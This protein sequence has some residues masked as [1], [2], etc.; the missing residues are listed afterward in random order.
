MH[1]SVKQRFMNIGAATAVGAVMAVLSTSAYAQV[2]SGPAQ[3]GTTL[4]ASKTIEIC[5]RADGQWEYSGEVSVWNSGV[6]NTEG[7]KIVD[8]IQSKIS[9]PTWT[10]RFTSDTVAP[11]GTV[12]PAGTTQLTALTFP[13]SFVGPALQ[14][15]IRNVAKVTITNHSGQLGKVFG[16]EPK[17]TYLGPKPPAPCETPPTGCTNTRGYWD[18]K[19]NVVWPEPYSRQA[20]FYYSG[21]TW[22]QVISSPAGGNNYYILGPQFIA[23][24]LNVA[25]G[26]SAPSGVQTVINNAQT[27]FNTSA[28]TPASCST[29]GSCG[30]Q[31][32]WAGILDDYNNG[33][34]PG[35]PPHCP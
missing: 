14:G 26:A 5:S 34:Y 20:T 17:A 21:Q 1:T 23:A 31:N 9:G 24:V 19:P 27:W 11:V 12:I 15:D 18:N 7:F 16:P 2:V 32:T 22:Q 30:L 6:I 13:Y 29:P 33:R 35:G 8:T 25:R 28:N 4:A 3:N 10:T